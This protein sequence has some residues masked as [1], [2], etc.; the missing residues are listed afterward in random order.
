M[1]FMMLK[2]EVCVCLCCWGWGTKAA[3]KLQ[4]G[5]GTTG[6]ATTPRTLEVYQQKGPSGDVSGKW[7]GAGGGGQ[8]SG[9]QHQ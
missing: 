9:E 7:T 2:A 3:N 6:T 8:A 1:L 4:R 5:D